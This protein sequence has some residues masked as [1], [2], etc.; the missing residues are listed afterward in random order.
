M[1]RGYNETFFD[2]YTVNLPNRRKMSYTP[3]ITRRETEL[4]SKGVWAVQINGGRQRPADL[5]R[6]HHAV[7]LHPDFIQN[8]VGGSKPLVAFSREECRGCVS[9]WFFSRTGLGGAGVGFITSG[10]QEGRY[11]N[12][13]W[14][15]LYTVCPQQ[16]VWIEEMFAELCAANDCIYIGPYDGV[17]ELK[18]QG[19]DGK[20]SAAD[21]RQAMTSPSAAHAFMVAHENNSYPYFKERLWRFKPC[22]MNQYFRG[23][24]NAHDRAGELLIT[25][26]IVSLALQHVGVDKEYGCP[27]FFLGKTEFAGKY[28]PRYIRLLDGGGILI[29]FD[30]PT[31]SQDFQLFISSESFRQFMLP[32][33][34]E[35]TG[36][37]GASTAVA[38]ADVRRESDNF[39][40]VHTENFTGQKAPVQVSPF[41]PG[42]T[43][44]C[45]HSPASALDMYGLAA[46]WY[47]K[48]WAHIPSDMV[49]LAFTKPD[50]SYLEV[51]AAFV[52]DCFSLKLPYVKGAESGNN[53]K[54]SITDYVNVL[55]STNTINCK[56]PSGRIVPVTYVTGGP[57]TIIGTFN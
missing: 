18:P 21:I 52:H 9:A 38:P 13:P 37:F 1:K 12:D 8:Y 2:L 40:L 33:N 39:L 43:Y 48:E 17:A 47:E 49:P 57:E 56:F 54:I 46:K 30:F 31:Y 26:I 19:V 41:D 23:S 6:R 28:T 25:F 50:G 16:Y 29:S 34:W 42:I 3:R 53:Y 5:H 22:V 20:Y 10:A 36:A 45:L 7:L 35:D 14:A 44:P 51:S 15:Q 32:F 24:D 55:S 27:F 11:E 4:V